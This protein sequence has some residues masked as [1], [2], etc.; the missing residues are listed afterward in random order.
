MAKVFLSYATPDRELADEVFAWLR[1]AGHDVFLDR[2]R[3][4]GIELGEDWKPR[5]YREL[6][7]G[8]AVVCLLTPA[9]LRS[10]WCTAEIAIAD[11]LGS[12]ILPLRTTPEP[13]PLL[14]RQQHSDLG[15][16]P[17]E[18]RSWLLATLRRIDAGGAREWRDGDNPYPGL[19]PFTEELT[20][21]FFGRAHETR[22]LAARVRADAGRDVVAV[23]GPSGCGKS[24]LLRAGLV[25]ALGDW[26]CLTPWQPG[27][28]PVSALARAVTTTARRHGLTWR[29]DEVRDR[30]TADHGL[31]HLTE[32]LL[33]DGPRRTRLLIPVDQ[34]EELFTRADDGQRARLGRLLRHALDGGSAKVV[35]TLRSE[36]LDDL[37]GLGELGRVEP[38]LLGP[39][40]RDMLQLAIAEPAS[41]AGLRMRPE[42]VARL[43][44]DTASG[45]ALP[46]L[47][48]ALQQ[49]AQDRTRGDAIGLADYDA[50][51]AQ[52][53]YRHLT[54]LHAVLAS[55]ADHALATA[56]RRSGLTEREVLTGLFRLVTLDDNDR[57][58][59]RRVVTESLPAD[60]RAALEVFVDHRLLT[61]DGDQVGLAH[62]ALLTAWPPL[63]ELLTEHSSALRTARVIE[64]AAADWVA[65]D[66]SETY[67]WDA[68]RLAELPRDAPVVEIDDDAARFLAA[69]RARADATRRR[70]RR[71]RV[72][73]T[74]ALAA[75]AVLAL[76][77]A[78]IAVRQ[79]DVAAA[80]RDAATVRSLI[81]QSDEVRETNPR[82][83]LRLAL[84]AQAISP[85]GQAAASLT[86]TLATHNYLSSAAG[87]TTPVAT[88]ALS[89]DGRLM[90]SGD[91]VD[92]TVRLWDVGDP[93][94]PPR[95][96]GP[97]LRDHSN[98][99][100]AAAFSPD[101]RTLA[102]LSNAEAILWDV[103]DPGNPVKRHTLLTDGRLAGSAD[104]SALGLVRPGS[105]GIA[106]SPDGRTLATT[107]GGLVLWD[108][109]SGGQPRRLSTPVRKFDT[110]SDVA[111]S[112][113]GR[114][115]AA[116][117]EQGADVAL[118]DV[119]DPA[120]PVEVGRVALGAE[121]EATS[122]AFDEDGATLAVATD[123]GRTDGTPGAVRLFDVRDP[124]RPAA[125]GGPITMRGQAVRDVTFS[126]DGRTLAIASG[127]R[128]VVLWDVTAPAAPRRVGLPL[129]D[130][131]GAVEEVAFTADGTRFATASADHRVILWRTTDPFQPTRVGEP[132]T[133]HRGGIALA[134]FRPGDGSLF[135]VE[136]TRSG[137]LWPAGAGSAD[138][139]RE[140]PHGM[141]ITAAAF[142]PDGRFLATGGENDT[143]QLW[144]VADPRA[145]SRFGEPIRG[146]PGRVTGL[147]FSA[148]GRTLRAAADEETYPE[149]ER[150]S[151]TV[152]EWDVS[153]PSRPRET[154]K[155]VLRDVD[156]GN[157]AGFSPDGRT[158]VA[159][160]S[161]DD[162]TALALWDVTTLS[163]VRR[164][165]P[166]GDHQAL[167]WA[168]RGDNALLATAGE[169][170]VL[171]DL[172]DREHPKQFGGV[173]AAT[174]TATAVALSP[175]G[176][177]MAVADEN[178]TV[179]L[180]DVQDPER[181]R[182]VAQPLAEHEPGRVT[183]LAFSSD[184]RALVTGDS[185]GKAVR[186]DVGAL[187]DLRARAVERACERA[188][189]DLTAD[190]WSRYVGPGHAYR[191]S[192]ST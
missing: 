55:R 117:A 85:D 73:F 102:T 118:F 192:C 158:M 167:G 8:D 41:I 116:T 65:A 147:A 160:T 84:A 100:L 57:R 47:A 51:A 18:A 133:G 130:H 72:G 123:R 4:R 93:D 19:E 170:V 127:D 12:R 164:I 140:L 183:A 75:L 14:D 159:T 83:A 6:R 2:D 98:W 7:R 108:V 76:I 60:V 182:R 50:L 143:V 136:R 22:E 53:G 87:H 110:H 173:V 187:P 66:R 77:G 120:H 129:T 181:P 142:S 20:G 157:G 155:A 185:A 171:W 28:D 33:T 112:P 58:T 149:T 107:N 59:Q 144:D 137:W 119:G 74:S 54:A 88:V 175:D 63:D 161:T 115:V 17:A 25:P 15:R 128:T 139:N 37:G 64:R 92:H 80:E 67:L 21:L 109:G 162:T 141:F 132:V 121:Q 81:L 56:V 131:D 99:V 166:L 111:F 146:L 103:G 13:H 124:A 69:S 152:A 36:F 169:E 1:D 90:A 135:T 106:F 148:D 26:L 16:D 52:S 68:D 178:T 62:E 43:V 3:R 79:A 49:L 34:G 190:E 125:L 150:H 163:D 153:D 48:F 44:G 82:L 186:W 27:D 156:G 168:F 95:Q 78:L 30:L 40:R 35:I 10:T 122:V 39:L 189:R 38:F 113:D 104:P 97:P 46:L 89:P 5:L 31:R 86:K 172:S 42:L 138:R 151:L 174:G 114:I 9:Y 91:T 45:E 126:P 24:S 11:S 188:V 180:W 154:A 145:V 61:V 32:E 70:A 177:T 101:G 134:L 96:L 71:R 94:A 176:R 191:R 184:G 23:T 105:L 29:L 179:Q 165:A